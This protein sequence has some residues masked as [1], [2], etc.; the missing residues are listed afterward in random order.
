MCDTIVLGMIFDIALVRGSAI[1]TAGVTNDR[2]AGKEGRDGA[3]S[4]W[5]GGLRDQDGGG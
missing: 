3:S 2:D 1:P 5:I 4:T